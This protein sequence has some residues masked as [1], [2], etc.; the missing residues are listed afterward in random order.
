MGAH[1]GILLMHRGLG[2]IN[3]MNSNPG[4]LRHRTRLRLL[5]T[6]FVERWEARANEVEIDLAPVRSELNEAV[7]AGDKEALLVV[8][9][10][11][12]G[13]IRQVE[14]AG[15]IV[16]ALVAEGAQFDL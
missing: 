12:A 5:R 7:A 2:F 1:S 14:P 3:A 6:E 13:L 16:R 9:D 11:S 10:Q 4:T 8:G 15:A